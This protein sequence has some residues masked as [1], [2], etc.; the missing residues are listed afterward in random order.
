MGTKL[1]QR[2]KK[3]LYF[4]GTKK[5]TISVKLFDLNKHLSLIRMT[6]H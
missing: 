1:K 4:L 2:F 3:S 6:H 5:L